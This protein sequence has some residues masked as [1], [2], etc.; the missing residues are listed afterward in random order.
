MELKY[1]WYQ[2]DTHVILEFFVKGLKDEQILIDL[3][4]DRVTLIY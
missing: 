3:N 4:G 2:T 1:S